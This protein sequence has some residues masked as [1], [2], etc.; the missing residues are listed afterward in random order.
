MFVNVCCTHSSG[1][2]LKAK[3]PPLEMIKLIQSKIQAVGLGHG[4]TCRL[5]NQAYK[6][7][8]VRLGIS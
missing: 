2:E 5:G 1:E 7:K 4:H 6:G 3:A 8:R